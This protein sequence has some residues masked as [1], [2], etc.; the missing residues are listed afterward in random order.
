MSPKK[1]T[2]KS[3]RST[4]TAI[5]KTTQVSM[6]RFHEPKEGNPEVRQEHH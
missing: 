5:G 6:R 4:T 2:Q 1:G 3:A